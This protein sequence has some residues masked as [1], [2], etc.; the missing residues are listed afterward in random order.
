L[1]EESYHVIGSGKFLMLT[2]GVRFI[3]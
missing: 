3:V 2:V 1:V